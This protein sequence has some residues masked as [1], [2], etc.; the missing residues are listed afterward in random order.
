MIRWEG[1]KVVGWVIR[2]EGDKEGEGGKEV[3]W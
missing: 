3:G 2:R 1:D